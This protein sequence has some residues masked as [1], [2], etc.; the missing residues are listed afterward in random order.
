MTLFKITYF[1]AKYI[2]TGILEEVLFMFM[3]LSKSD[4]ILENSLDLLRGYLIQK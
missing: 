1:H 4:C 3:N 2:L